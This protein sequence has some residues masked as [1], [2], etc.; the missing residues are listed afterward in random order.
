MATETRL[1]A[2]RNKKLLDAHPPRVVQA[3]TM[4][5]ALRFVYEPFE[6]E[7][8]TALGYADLMRQH[9]DVEI[10]KAGE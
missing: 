1:Y 7:A 5:Q 2:I 10:E 4:A 3:K 8:L 9:P 6:A